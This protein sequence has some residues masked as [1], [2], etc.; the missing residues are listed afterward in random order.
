MEQLKTQ[1]GFTLIEVLIATVVLGITFTVLLGLL[2]QAQ[3]DLN[4]AKTLSINFLM[5]DSSIKEGR[6]EGINVK[7]R[8]INILSIPVIE[9]TYEKDGV[10]IKTYQAK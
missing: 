6:F 10:Y 5:L 1:K 2:Y 7:V 8:E 9:T 3:R 4:L